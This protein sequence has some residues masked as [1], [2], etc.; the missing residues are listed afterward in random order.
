MRKQR[1][2]AHAST[3]D[4]S[5]TQH[6]SRSVAGVVSGFTVTR[7]GTGLRSAL[8]RWQAKGEREGVPTTPCPTWR[9]GAALRWQAKGE[10]TAEVSAR[11]E[12][13]S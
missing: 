2:Y 3:N 11:L 4:S 12:V 7:G 1:T 5:V 6:V 13:N 10:V 8:A 9:A